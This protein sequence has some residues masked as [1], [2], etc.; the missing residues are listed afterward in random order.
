MTDDAHKAVDVV[1]HC[2]QGD[3]DILILNGFWF[4]I[5]NQGGSQ[6]KRTAT[7]GIPVVLD[8]NLCYSLYQL[9]VDFQRS[10]QNK[11]KTPLTIT[12]INMP[13][14]RSISRPLF[15]RVSP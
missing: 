11:S 6:S 12:K 1:L 10:N 3:Y 14:S 9:T 8:E 13:W 2:C 15:D 4:Y 7:T 5:R